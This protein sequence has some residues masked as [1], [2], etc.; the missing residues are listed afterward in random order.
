[1]VFAIAQADGRSSHTKNRT[2]DVT[3]HNLSCIRFD[4][5]QDL[6]L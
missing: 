6:L 3:L 5:A 1:M 2:I 4:L